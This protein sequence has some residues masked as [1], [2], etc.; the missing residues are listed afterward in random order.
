MATTT[1]MRMNEETK[2]MEESKE[3]LPEW[4]RSL[5]NGAIREQ[6]PPRAHD[7]D[8]EKPTNEVYHDPLFKDF[9][10][11]FKAAR[12]K[13]DYSYH[14]NPAKSR[15]EL[16]DVI[17]ARVVQA[18]LQANQQHPQEESKEEVKEVLPEEPGR[19]PWIVFS[20]GPM[21]VG[22]GYVMATLNERGLFPLD[23]FLKI[24]PDLL[25]TE[26]PEMPG[27]LRQDPASAATKV[28]REST[29]MA[30]VLLEHALQKRIPTLVDGSLRDVEYYRSFMERV[31]RE[32]PE[33]QLAIL[34]VTAAPDIIRA[35]A[36]SRAEKTGRAV[37]EALLTASIEQVPA[38][39]EA[40]SPH[41]DVV[42]TISNEEDQPLKL[43]SREETAAKKTEKK[44][45]K[46]L[47]SLCAPKT[48]TST[49]WKDFRQTWWTTLNGN[50]KKVCR[51]MPKWCEKQCPGMSEFKTCWMNSACIKSAKAVYSS[52]YPSFCP[53][54]TMAGGLCGMCIHDKHWCQCKECGPESAAMKMKKKECSLTTSMNSLFGGKKKHGQPA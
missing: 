35:R 4:V 20:A 31:R 51:F 16:Q 14:R 29:Q 12:E 13:L 46:I 10:P 32:F 42:F 54:C 37:P 38:S 3:D 22:K 6:W 30:D 50:E 43:L 36:Q 17:L 33:Y 26:L 39:V 5:Q 41:V 34:H 47:G 53:G 28:H 21:G 27:Y 9:S 18:A 19:R 15:Q 2:T 40:L 8:W 7:I 48:D 25:K 24:D 52:A 45:C 44:E 1:T 11:E 23:R 49:S